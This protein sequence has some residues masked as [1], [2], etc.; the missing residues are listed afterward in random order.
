MEVQRVHVFIVALVLVVLLCAWQSPS[1]QS[2][3]GE[4]HLITVTGAAEIRVVPD[5][6]VLVLGVE[7]WDKALKVAKSENDQRVQQALTLIQDYGIAPQHIK[8]DYINIQPGDWGLEKR[9]G[10]WV[11]KTIV[12]TLRDLSKFEDLLTGALDAGV[13]HVHTVQVHTT[14]LREHK[15][16]ARALAIHAA[17]EK[18]DALAGELGQRVQEPFTIRE[19]QSGWWYGSGAWWGSRWGNAMAQNV[20]QEVNGYS[21]TADSSIAPGQIT[22]NARVTVSFAFEPAN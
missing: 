14:A 20:V 5:E 7:T 1:A 19:D 11:R 21:L 2:D 8:T 9:D 3:L 10:Y 22:V 13:T 15:D 17:Q 16:Q 4:T 6:V 18:A 12:V